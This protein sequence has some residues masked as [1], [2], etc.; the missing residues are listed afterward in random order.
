MN[1]MGHDIPNMIGVKQPQAAINKV[2]PEYMA[3][4]KNGMSE[5]QVHTDMGHMQGPE[6]TLPMMM[7][8]GRYGKME[9]G[10]MFTL[11]K[12][13]DEINGDPGMYQPEVGTQARK[14]KK[15]PDGL[16]T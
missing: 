16:P 5:H 7:G 12:V 9:M 1:A 8:T 14:V 4:G 10:G 3:M 15:V 13:R 11:V 2:L 6:N